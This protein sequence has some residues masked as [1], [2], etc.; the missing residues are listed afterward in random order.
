MI[1]TGSGDFWVIERCTDQQECGMSKPFDET[2][3]S[4]FKGTSEPYSIQYMKGETSGFWAQDVVSIGEQ[5]NLTW[6]G[7]SKV[8]ADRL[9]IG[10]ANVVTEWNTA[11]SSLIG[12]SFAGGATGHSPWWMQVVS[13]WEQPMFSIFY[14]RTAD[15]EAAYR[16]PVADNGQVT[17]GGVDTSKYVGDINFVDVMPATGKPIYWEVPMDG[18]KVGG[19]Q[20]QL[21]ALRTTSS[22]GFGRRQGDSPLPSATMGGPDLP[23]PSNYPMPASLPASS[24]LAVIDSGTTLIYV[25]AQDAEALYRAIPGSARVQGKYYFKQPPQGQS[26]NL[27]FTF[28]GIDYPVY[29]GDL[30][31][32]CASASRLGIARSQ[33][34]YCEGTIQGQTGA[35]DWLI[36]QAFMKNVYSVFRNEPM[37]VG[38]AKLADSANVVYGTPWLPASGP[39]AGS[40]STASGSGSTNGVGSSG[41]NS[42]NSGSGSNG[43]SGSGASRVAVSGGAAVAAVLASAWLL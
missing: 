35:Q 5:S 34:L 11:Q 4:T 38:F 40:G 14:G 9:T 32:Q 31:W 41:S 13:G 28:N 16:Q 6:F 29:D 18:V 12:F 43:S 39:G 3:S 37:S 33:E 36:G 15:D 7:E 23:M 25:P 10:A 30:A 17:L 22:S 8:K 1:D 27:A 42:G 2:Q 24:R 26:I 21:T 19:K 20:V